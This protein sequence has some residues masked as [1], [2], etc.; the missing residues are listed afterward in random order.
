VANAIRRS[1]AGLSDPKRPIGSFICSGGP[2]ANIANGRNIRGTDGTN[3]RLAPFVLSKTI[4]ITGSI[5]M[6]ESDLAPDILVTGVI[7]TDAFITVPVLTNAYVIEVQNQT[8][9]AGSLYVKKAGSSTNVLV[10]LGQIARVR[11]HP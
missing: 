5:T 8:S 9:G 6:N 11:I 3:G 4:N 10:P 7:P 2:V 1:R